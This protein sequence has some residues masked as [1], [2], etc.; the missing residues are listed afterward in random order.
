M[1][2]CRICGSREVTSLLDCGRQPICNRFLLR[3]DEPQ[4]LFPIAL[5]QCRRCA[6]VQLREPVPV[7][8]LRPRFDWISYN[9]PEGHL[10]RVVDALV[11]LPG[12]SPAS[13]IAGVT[14]KDDTTLDRFRARGF[15]STYRIEP[16]AD[17]GVCDPRSGIET[18]QA[19]LTPER[20]REIA[21]RH[22]PFDVVLARHI[23]EHA[24]DPGAFIAALKSMLARGGWLVLEAPDC[25]RAL[26][27]LEYGT[28]W[29]EHILYLTQGTFRQLLARNGLEIG[30]FSSWPYAL[31]DC[32]VT[33]SREATPGAPSQAAQSPPDPDPDLERGARFGR[34]FGDAGVRL[35]ACLDRARSEGREVAFFGAGHLTATVINLLGIGDRVR[36]V[37]DDNPNKRGLF[38][39]GSR[40]PIVGSSELL[41]SGIG[42]AVLCLSPEAE[43]KVIARN[44]AFVQAGGRF[45][46]IFAGSPHFLGY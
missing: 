16:A 32:L 15:T 2:S 33:A 19:A 24:Y 9:E 3:A 10:D 18:L 45:A 36:F 44:A 31:E 17:L 20:A 46:S 40:L 25:S 23:V 35:R 26:D 29:E 8:E 27:A 5:E 38:M 4:A 11:A 34:S 12:V 41:A 21:H 7:D 39:P 14:F 42:L 22:G 30:H 28:I 6:G 1:S 13:R 43:D 37:V